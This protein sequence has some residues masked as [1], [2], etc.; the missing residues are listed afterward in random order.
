MDEMGIMFLFIVSWVSIDGLAR[1]TSVS[2]VQL[3]TCYY[4]F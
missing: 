2:R 3:V 4:T 1:L